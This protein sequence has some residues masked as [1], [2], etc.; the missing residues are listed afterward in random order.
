MFQNLRSGAPFYILYKSEPKL[1]IGEVVSV[2]AP[3]PQFG[4][5]YQNGILTPPKSTVD[6]KVS[7]SGEDVMLQSLPSDLSIADFGSSGMVVSE[8]KDAIQSEIDAFKSTSVRALGEVER[9]KKI[10]SACDEMLC[11]LNPQ[12]AREAEQSSRIDSLEGKL[13]NIEQMLAK[14]LGRNSKSKEE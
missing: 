13:T 5:T 10:V 9:H 3:V 12:I 1:S 11:A 6:V 8:S 7:V 2:G 4:N 14:V